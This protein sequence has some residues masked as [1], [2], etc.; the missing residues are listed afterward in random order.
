MPR[1]ERNLRR[2][3]SKPPAILLAFLLLAA[4]SISDAQEQPPADARGNWTI[5]S[6]NIDNNE[7]VTKHVQISQNGDKLTGHF[8][9]PNQSGGIQG[10]VTGH[11]IEFSTKTRNV[12][13]FRGE[14]D[15]NKM[16]GLY[17]I[18][19]RHAEWQAVRDN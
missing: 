18:H 13:T 10:T 8:E 7:T 14:I 12:L 9:G 16:S 3:F 5:Y 4:G 17:G 19:G 2:H 15:G 1:M 6:K 11:H